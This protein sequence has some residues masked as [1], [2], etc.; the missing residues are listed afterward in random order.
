M[1][2][3]VCLAVLIPIPIKVR[4][5]TSLCVPGGFLILICYDLCPK[6]SQLQRE[7]CAFWIGKAEPNSSTWYLRN[8]SHGTVRMVALRLGVPNWL[9]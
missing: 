1:T 4:N 5:W 7:G 8:P 9:P 2:A 6:F 3:A